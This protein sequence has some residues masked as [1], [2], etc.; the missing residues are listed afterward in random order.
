MTAVELMVEG[1]TCD[2]CVK[3]V[4]GALRPLAGVQSVNVDLTT[5]RVSITGDADSTALIAALE[6]AG[7]PARLAGARKAGGSCCGGCCG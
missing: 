1:M 7:Y 5:G 3:H 2:T 6:D 4:D